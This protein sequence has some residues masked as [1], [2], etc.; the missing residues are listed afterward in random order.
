VEYRLVRDP[1]GRFVE[2]PFFVNGA[3]YQASAEYGDAGPAAARKIVLDNPAAPDPWEFEL[4]EYRQGA[5][6]LARIGHGGA[7]SFAAPEYLETRTNE[8]WYDTEGLAQGFFSLEYRLEDGAR[9]L[10][11]TDSRSDQDERILVYDYNSSGRVSGI[12]APEGEYAALYNA[13][14]RPRYWERP[15]GAYT[16]QW[17]EQGFLVRITGVSWDA[18][19]SLGE[20]AAEP[21]QIDIRYEYT[22]DGRGNWI[23]RREIA[24]VRRFGRLVPGSETAIRRIINY[25][26]N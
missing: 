2:F 20:G 4:L 24:F 5:P 21:Q 6:A 15:G 26:D 25:G 19:A 1:A 13:A 18:K 22:L 23:E 17:D 11:A 14:A 10:V 7:W 16:L 12:S 8:T 9:R 3:L